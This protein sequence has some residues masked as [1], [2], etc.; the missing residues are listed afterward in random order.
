M[1]KIHTIPRPEKQKIR[2]KTNWPG[3]CQL[4]VYWNRANK[5]L[6]KS[7][8][9]ARL[10][11]VL[12]APTSQMSKYLLVL[13]SLDWS[14]SN[15]IVYNCKNGVSM[16]RRILAKLWSA[17]FVKI[18]LESIIFRNVFY[19]EFHLLQQQLLIWLSLNLLFLGS[20]TLPFPSSSSISLLINLHT[21]NK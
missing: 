18:E 2:L 4:F 5:K 21:P 17:K 11:C 7:W 16:N 3:F 6:R 19:F 9:L 13:L 12:Y 8:K 14:V 10:M 15:K 1:V 20:I